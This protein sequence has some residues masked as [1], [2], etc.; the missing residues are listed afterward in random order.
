MITSI[1]FVGLC[2]AEPDNAVLPL[3]VQLVT[4]RHH[5]NAGTSCK[6]IAHVE[7]WSEW[8]LVDLSLHR[9]HVVNCRLM[10]EPP[11]AS[12]P[13]GARVYRGCVLP[14]PTRVLPMPMWHRSQSAN[15]CVR[16]V[17]SCCVGDVVKWTCGVLERGRNMSVSQQIFCLFFDSFFFWGENVLICFS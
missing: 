8:V 10:S 1:L 14:G 17:A 5:T 7:E 9:Y 4:S 11:T 16:R 12:S 3:Q 2:D 15:S 13:W 6:P